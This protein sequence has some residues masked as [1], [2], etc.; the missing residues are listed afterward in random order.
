MFGYSVINCSTCFSYIHTITIFTLNLV[1]SVGLLKCWCF[2]FDVQY[3]LSK[4]I[5]ISITELNIEGAQYTLDAL[6]SGLNI[7]SADVLRVLSCFISG[8]RWPKSY[9]NHHTH[10]IGRD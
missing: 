3:S 7:G 8:S 9:I 5:V 6:T 10:T 1:D 4:C 2:I